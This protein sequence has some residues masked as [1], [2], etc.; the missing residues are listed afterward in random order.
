[1]KK[2]DVIR[3]LVAIGF[4]LLGILLAPPIILLTMKYVD[5]CVKWIGV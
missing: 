2:E 3:L 5:L 4:L 1:M